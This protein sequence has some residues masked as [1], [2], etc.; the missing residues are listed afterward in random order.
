MYIVLVFYGILFV[1]WLII[2]F[3]LFNFPLCF[4]LFG[5]AKEGKKKN[6]ALLFMT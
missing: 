3:F 4:V 2:M 5:G 6:R 1:A